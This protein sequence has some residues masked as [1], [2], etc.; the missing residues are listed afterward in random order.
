LLARSKPVLGID[1]VRIPA[2][3]RQMCDGFARFA[4]K[5]ER[6]GAAQSAPKKI[7]W[8]VEHG[9]G[10]V[11]LRASAASG[12]AEPFDALVST[13]QML[14][15][16]A[17]NHRPSF[18]AAELAAHLNCSVDTV[19]SALASLRAPKHPLVSGL[20]LPSDPFVLSD[21][22]PS[23]SQLHCAGPDGGRLLIVHR[24]VP[25]TPSS[26]ANADDLL[27]LI[28][29]SVP[30]LRRVFSDDGSAIGR[31]ESVLGSAQGIIGLP[32]LGAFPLGFV[33]DVQAVRGTASTQKPCWSLPSIES[34]LRHV[35]RFVA[36]RYNME[37]GQAGMNPD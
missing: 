14:I 33:G 36:Q 27:G 35:T 19:V 25:S 28:P 12:D 3:L 18:T 6:R 15:L 11:T 32:D 20:G 5:R 37:V 30:S 34:A 31:S 29:P 22:S 23:P 24:L 13:L 2:E 26:A 9:S 10:I 17:F 4:S 16:E 1:T 7:E 8:S 21:W